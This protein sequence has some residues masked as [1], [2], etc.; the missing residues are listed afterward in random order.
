MNKKS[1]TTANK[2]PHN[3]L[4]MSCANV[5]GCIAKTGAPNY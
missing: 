5:D 4:C 2:R 1:K 3:E